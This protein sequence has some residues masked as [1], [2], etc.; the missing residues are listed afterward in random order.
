MIDNPQKIKSII[1]ALI[2]PNKQVP[3]QIDAEELP[4]EL[5]GKISK[6]LDIR[7]SAEELILQGVLDGLREE[8]ATEGKLSPQTCKEMGIILHRMI[9]TEAVFRIRQ[10][11]DGVTNNN[12]LVINFHEILSKG[13]QRIKKYNEQDTDC[14]DVS[15]I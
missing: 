9:P 15:D 10:A 13:Q 4:D 14:A 3:A 1:P 12:T 5:R 6:M 8:L 11:I 7:M 2:P